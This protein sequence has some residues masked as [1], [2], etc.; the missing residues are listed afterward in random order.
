MVLAKGKY[1]WQ[2]KAITHSSDMLF[3]IFRMSINEMA[4]RTS[5]YAP[6][7]RTMADR[8]S[9]YNYAIGT[10]KNREMVSR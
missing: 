5:S 4:T 6:L 2:S 8:W 7:P 10:W 1:V 9:I 3:L